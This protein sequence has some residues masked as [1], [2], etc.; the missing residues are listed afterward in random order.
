MKD[1][2]PAERALIGAILQ[3]AE[4]AY[5]VAVAAGVVDA[6]FTDALCR[7][8]WMAVRRLRDTGKPV[9]PLTVSELMRGEQSANLLALGE[10]MDLCPTATNARAYAEQVADAYRRES[11]RTAARLAV[12]TLE[13]GGAVDDVAA[14]LRAAGEAVEGG[15]VLIPS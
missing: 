9:D 7:D 1:S 11:L 5:P 4:S 15:G 3:D 6:A 8:A 10:C 14:Q 12:E 2:M 13:K